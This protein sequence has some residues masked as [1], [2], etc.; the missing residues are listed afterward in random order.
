MTPDERAAL[1]LARQEIGE[2]RLRYARATDQIG[3]GNDTDAARATYHA[4]FAADAQ[5]SADGVDPAS[6]PD[7]WYKI[8]ADA[9]ATY[10]ATQHLIGTVLVDVDAL[11]D[12]DGEGG[13]A[14][15][16]SYL[17]AWHSTPDNQLWL[18]IGTYED[19]CVSTP[20]GWQISRMH[21]R[22]VSGDNRQIDPG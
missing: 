15:M 2:L 19:E 18:F 20:D 10:S 17:Q 22:K 14:R 3:A 9:L 5:I 1:A 11:P 7:A 4:I 21:L 16:T 12:A 6:G 13:R 8:V